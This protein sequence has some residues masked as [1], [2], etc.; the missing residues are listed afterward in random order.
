MDHGYGDDLWH[1]GDEVEEEEEEVE[2]APTDPVDPHAYNAVP[3]DDGFARPLGCNHALKMRGHR[4]GVLVLDMANDQIYKPVKGRV[5]GEDFVCETLNVLQS[6][7]DRQRIAGE[8]ERGGERHPCPGYIGLRLHTGEHR[9][10]KYDAL[11]LQLRHRLKLRLVIA[12][13]KV[14]FPL[15]V[16]LIVDSDFVRY[17]CSFFFFLCR[18]MLPSSSGCS[19]RSI[20]PTRVACLLRM[21]ASGRSV[22]C[23]TRY[24]GLLKMVFYFQAVMLAASD[25]LIGLLLGMALS[26]ETRP[27]NCNVHS[28]VITLV[29]FISTPLAM[30]LLTGSQ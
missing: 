14:S 12:G 9:F 24:G 29:D 16:G 26:V 6:L 4:G 5:S 8:K 17:L 19:T 10:L 11:R 7:G 13:S 15:F 21:S 30:N 1:S 18:L 28:D 20:F 3:Y 2:E 25:P 22:P 23:R 27:L